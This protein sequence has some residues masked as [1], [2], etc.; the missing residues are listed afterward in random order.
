MSHPEY[1]PV[2]T[3]VAALVSGD[4][5]MSADATALHLGMVKPDGTI[6]RRGFHERVACRSD[7]PQ[8]LAI[9]SEKKW[10]RSEVDQW[11]EDQRRA[12]RA[13]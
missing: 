13:A 5:W 10:K 4:P 7:F 1:D 2:V 12:N 6:N 9:G 3:L 11:A 8:P